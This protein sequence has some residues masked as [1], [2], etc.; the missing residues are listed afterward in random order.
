MAGMGIPGKVGR[1]LYT[2]QT[3]RSQHGNQVISS[4]SFHGNSS[5]R[6][7]TVLTPLLLRFLTCDTQEDRKYSLI[8]SFSDDTRL[9]MKITYV[10][11]PGKLQS[12]I[13]Q[14]FQLVIEIRLLLN[15]DKFQLRRYKGSENINLYTARKMI[16]YI[17]KD[18]C[19]RSG[20]DNVG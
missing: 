9:S 13:S 8:S 11:Y 14:V 16:L 19:K 15:G 7:G 2:F 6:Q 17:T 10:E 1:W 12:D 4:A 20:G 18:K 3:N 5:A